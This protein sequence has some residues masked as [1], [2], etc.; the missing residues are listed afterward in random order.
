MGALADAG[1][2]GDE[3]GVHIG[4]L[5]IIA[6]V[7]AVHGHEGTVEGALLD[8]GARTMVG[9]GSCAKGAAEYGARDGGEG[10]DSGAIR[11]HFIEFGTVDDPEQEAFVSG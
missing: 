10:Q 3:A 2:S 4:Y 7:T 9:R 11:A 1:T 8:A 6:M 5:R